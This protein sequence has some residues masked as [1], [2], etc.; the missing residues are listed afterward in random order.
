[1]LPEDS[2]VERVKT[3]SR[4]PKRKARDKRSLYQCYHARCRGAQ[5]A[6]SRGHALGSKDG[7][8]SILRLARGEPLVYRACQGCKD[9]GEMGNPVDKE[10]RGWV[11]R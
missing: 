5:I 2:G 8:V 11:K 7:T 4:S 3:M 9:Y 6:C 1:M 10:D